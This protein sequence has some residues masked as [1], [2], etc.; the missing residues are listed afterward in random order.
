MQTNM[1]KISSFILS[2]V[3][4]CFIPAVTVSADFEIPGTCQVRADD[5]AAGTVKILDYDYV[6]NTYLSLRDVAMVLKDTDK[7]FSLSITQN[8]VALTTGRDYVPVGGENVSWENDKNKDVTLKRNAFTVNDQKVVYHTMITRLP[9]GAY[10]CFMMTVDLA[11]LLDVNITASGFGSLQIH[12][13]EPFC[14]SPA[15]LEEADYFWG[16]NSVYIG[17]ATTGELYY[18]YQSDTAYPIASTSKLMTCLLTMEAVS[19]G[20]LDLEDTVT[21]SKEAALLAAS[22]DGVIPLEEGMRITVQDLLLGLLLPSSNECAFCL[23]ETVAGSEETFVGM[24]N[25]KAAEIGLSQA[26]FFNSNGLP[27][28]TKNA[29]PSKQQ[30]RMS[31]E[32]MFKLASYLLKVYP[33]VKEI[34]S[35]KEAVLPSLNNIKV[36]NSNPLLHNLSQATGLKTGTTNRAGACLVTSLAVEDGAQEHDL[37]VVVFGTED[38]IERGRVSGVLARYALHAFYDGREEPEDEKAAQTAGNLPTHAEA[39]VERVIQTAKKR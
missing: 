39:A 33:Q 7:S 35:L 24:M 8:S 9:S 20:R 27:V 16:V 25:Q 2:V 6:N 11:M 1:R 23:A 4:I 5:G 3:L 31:T 26:V 34:T 32:D 13:D 19:E 22:D 30:N 37:V 28:Y 36:N 12:T 18:Q 21:V 38:S 29:V 17:D 10:D 15:E 14:V